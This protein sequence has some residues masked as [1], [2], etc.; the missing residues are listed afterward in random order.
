M[1]TIFGSVLKEAL[2]KPLCTKRFH[3]EFHLNAS[4]SLTR[5]LWNGHMHR[6]RHTNSK[7]KILYIS[8][9]VN[10]I[11]RKR[12][13]SSK[14]IIVFTVNQSSAVAA[15]CVC[16]IVEIAE[17]GEC[18]KHDAVNSTMAPALRPR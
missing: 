12:V 8:R 14:I 17:N 6:H 15:L 18:S 16:V 5:R 13:F 2:T 3:F 4:Q 1:I 7:Q 9:L 11:S 10:F